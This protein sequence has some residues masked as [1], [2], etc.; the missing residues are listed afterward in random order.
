MVMIIDN[1]FGE[2]IAAARKA[3]KL[4]KS[5]AA[6]RVGIVPQYMTDIEIGRV[7]PNEDKIERLVS[8]LELDEYDTFKLA[9]KI[10]LWAMEE[11]KIK[12]FSQRGEAYGKD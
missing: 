5:E 3:K 2:H 9:D 6:R 8:V 1:K 12:Y 10:P 11:A 7:I 4:T